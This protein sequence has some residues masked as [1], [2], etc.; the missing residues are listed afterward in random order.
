MVDRVKVVAK[1]K[2]SRAHRA[3]ALHP[4]A[5]TALKEAHALKAKA[6]V[7]AKVAVMVA[8]MASEK[9]G[10]ILVRFSRPLSA[11]SSAV[12]SRSMFRSICR[13]RS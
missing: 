2:V 9:V 5:A 1:A 11:T 4:L 10:E 13:L 12:I 7:V 8:V 6:M 3:M